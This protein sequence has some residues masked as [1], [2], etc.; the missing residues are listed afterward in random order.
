MF[1]L[2]TM[3]YMMTISQALIVFG[4]A[5]FH[6][7]GQNCILLVTSLSQPN[8]TAQNLNQ[9]TIHWLESQLESE[10]T[11][12]NK[13]LPLQTVEPLS[14]LLNEGGSP[15]P[16]NEGGSKEDLLDPFSGNF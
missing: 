13:M 2:N 11:T 8:W 5:L 14:V 3:L 6:P 15:T 7:T 9:S 12:V 16:Q 4:L 1:R 10:P